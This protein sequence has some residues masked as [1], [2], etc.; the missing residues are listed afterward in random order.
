MTLS[1]RGLFALALMPVLAACSSTVVPMPGPGAGLSPPQLTQGAILA[2]I[3]GTRARYG[4]PPLR[5]NTQLESAARVQARL[6]ASKDQLSHD[7]GL[8][9]HRRVVD[10]GFVGASG[11]N[12]AGGQRTL[13]QAI[14][15]WLNSKGHRE[16]LLSTRFEEFG[17]AVAAVPAGKNSRYGIYWAFIAGGPYSAWN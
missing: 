3:N 9:L 16:T 8:S 2:A 4:K 12:V 13:E 1:R 14:A 7:L 5:Y 17:L 10:S 15:G 6:M 11:E